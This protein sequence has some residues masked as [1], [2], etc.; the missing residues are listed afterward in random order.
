MHYLL[1]TAMGVVQRETTLPR[2]VGYQSAINE[3]FSG[4]PLSRMLFVRNRGYESK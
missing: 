1:I 2:N 3:D 4:R